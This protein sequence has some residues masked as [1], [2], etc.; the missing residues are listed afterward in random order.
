[1]ITIQE[2]EKRGDGVLT[3]FAKEGI[4]ITEHVYPSLECDRL[5]YGPDEYA[6]IVEIS[7]GK[8]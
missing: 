4:F 2:Y 7:G 3:C 1:M 8:A 6:T 5:T